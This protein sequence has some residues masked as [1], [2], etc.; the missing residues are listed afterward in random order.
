MRQTRQL[1]E[2]LL[3]V[4]AVR[5]AFQLQQI[6]HCGPVEVVAV[7]VVVIGMDVLVVV[8]VVVV[9]V[10]RC[11]CR[12]TVRPRVGCHDTRSRGSCGLL[13]SA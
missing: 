3:Y 11:R 5:L 7:A 1:V 12:I 10:G 8:I 4:R 9:V 2:G 6:G 13:L